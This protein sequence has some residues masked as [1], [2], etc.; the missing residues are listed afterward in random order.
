MRPAG[1]LDAELPTLGMSHSDMC[2]TKCPKP[3]PTPIGSHCLIPVGRFRADSDELVITQ[4]SGLHGK[5]YA[6]CLCCGRAEA[7]T[8]EL[9]SP[10]MLKS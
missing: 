10:E 3:L 4:S 1:F 8:D 6:L 2:H 9:R 5:G 7:E